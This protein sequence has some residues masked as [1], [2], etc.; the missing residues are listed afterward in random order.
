VRYRA[1]DDD[2]N[3]QGSL[4]ASSPAAKD[5]LAIETFRLPKVASFHVDRFAVKRG[6]LPPRIRSN[7]IPDD[8]RNPCQ[9]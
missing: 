6:G 1:A 9:A 4:L 8:P 3:G 7:A 2:G 5:L